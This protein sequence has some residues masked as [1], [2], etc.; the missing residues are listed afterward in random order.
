MAYI[1]EH[2][3]GWRAQIYR[4]GQRVSKK[5]LTREEAT[6]WADSTERRMDERKAGLPAPADTS[7]LALVSAPVSVL[8]ARRSIPYF[9][10]DILRAAIPTRLASG[11]YFLI[12]DGEIV[13]V[14]Q[15]VDVLHRIAR[16]RREGRQFDAYS[17]IECE[18][19]DLD[20]LERTYI[21]AF[22]PEG[23]LSFGNADRLMHTALRP[24]QRPPPSP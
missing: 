17:F 21:R 11:V 13:Y 18:P 8:R 2:K 19:S 16:H 20:D 22:V 14:G 24:E 7:S 12:R 10:G 6:I 15:S 5:F 3:Q 1:H 9:E 4:H 23:N